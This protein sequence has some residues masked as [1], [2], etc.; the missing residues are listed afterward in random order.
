MERN[1]CAFD[2]VMLVCDLLHSV[3]KNHFF[4][5][6]NFYQG[7]SYF[8]SLHFREMFSRRFCTDSKLEKSDPLHLFG[9]RDILSKRSIV[10]A[11]SVRTMRT[12]HLDLPLCL[13]ASN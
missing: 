6:M 4:V 5:M 11:S 1:K 9:Q 7:F 13:E 3:G 10:K 2:S 8:Q 12:F